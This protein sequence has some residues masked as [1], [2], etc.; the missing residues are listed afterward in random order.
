MTK[1]I[2]IIAANNGAET[3]VTLNDNATILEALVAAVN[4]GFIK[5]A[6]VEEILELND[7]DA[8]GFNTELAD[9]QFDDGDVILLD[10]TGELVNEGVQEEQI[11]NDIKVKVAVAGGITSVDITIPT[12]STTFQA[13]QAGRAVLNNMTDNQITSAIKY[14]NDVE[15]SDSTVLHDGDN[16]VVAVRCAGVKGSQNYTLKVHVA[17]TTITKEIRGALLRLSKETLINSMLNEYENS[18]EDFDSMVYDNCTLSLD[19]SFAKHWL[20]APM[21]DNVELELIDHDSAYFND[22]MTVGAEETDEYEEDG[23]QNVPHIITVVLP[24]GLSRIDY[25]IEEGTTIRDVVTSMRILA[26]TGLNQNQA[27]SMRYTVNDVVVQL[28]DT[29]DYG[30]EL[31]MY[32]REA[33]VKG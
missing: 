14:V 3:I 8:T 28:D 9:A 10:T 27:E 2:T 11:S 16:V 18:L 19:S 1:S 20:Q 25:D 33:G 5:V 6:N 12:G 13:C 24:G 15:A 30:D 7:L 32:T 26:V 29:L 17:G 31:A 4:K 23:D 22:N 21:S